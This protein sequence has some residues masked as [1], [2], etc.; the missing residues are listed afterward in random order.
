[1]NVIVGDATA[2]CCLPGTLCK[3]KS[4]TDKRRFAYIDDI[5]P[6]IAVVTPMS[7]DVVELDGIAL[8]GA[9]RVFDAEVWKQ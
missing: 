4:N 2:G 1:M 9:I 6:C 8:V 7:Y 5:P 3:T